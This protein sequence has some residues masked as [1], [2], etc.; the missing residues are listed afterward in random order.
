MARGKPRPAVAK[1]HELVPGQSADFFAL[2]AERTKATTRDGKPYYTCKFRDNKRTAECK[3]WADHAL[4]GE[5]DQHWVAGGFYKLRGVFHEH[6]RYG[7]QVEVYQVREV[8]DEDREDGFTESDFY[9]RSRFDSDA[10]FSEL[11]ALAEAEVKDGPL[12][13]LVLGLLDANA[14][15]LKYLPADPRRYFPFPGGWLEH[16][17]SVTRSCLL[18]A[19][20][21]SAHYPELTPPLNRDLIVAGAVL[22]EI[23]RVGELAAGLPGQPAE[24]TVP[25]HLLG[26]QLLG[27]DMIRD[28]A[29]VV[30]DLSPELL[31]LLEHVIVSHLA[32]PNWG[33][34]R[35]PMI[36]E[37]LILH[38]A[39][40][41]DAKLETYVR[42]LTRDTADG[43]LTERDAVIGRPLLKGRSV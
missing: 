4:F 16:T 7:P 8:R 23:G 1:L 29:K 12:R 14:V 32:L 17:L 6:E 13:A 42:C 27:R 11:R 30:S 37:V 21:Y 9:E 26:H 20:R 36:P 33:S 24:P 34:V 39:D 43:P 10:M 25:G 38:H 18:L 31:T 22:H 35:Q 15:A 2:L 40:D 19:D 28:A 41:L 3:V 5:C